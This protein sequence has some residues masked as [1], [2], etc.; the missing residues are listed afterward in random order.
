MFGWE[1]DW[2]QIRIWSKWPQTIVVIWYQF[3]VGINWHQ[4]DVRFGQP[5]IRSKTSCTT[6]A[7]G[8]D[9]P[10]QRECTFCQVSRSKSVTSHSRPPLSTW[11]FF[12]SWAEWSVGTSGSSSFAHFLFLRNS[13][14][15]GKDHHENTQAGSLDLP[16]RANGALWHALLPCR[17]SW[18]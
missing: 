17:K 16:I 15:L 14:T 18:E 12:A 11:V 2:H 6:A 9:P 7:S 3:D 4:I 13:K 10:F 8:W 5:C 1:S